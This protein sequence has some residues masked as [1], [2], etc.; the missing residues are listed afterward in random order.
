M[1]HGVLLANIG[2]PDGTGAGPTPLQVKA[3]LKEF[4]MDPFVIDIPFPIRWFLVNRM[5][6]PQRSKTSAEAYHKIWNFN[7]NEGSPLLSSMLKLVIK[8]Q[9]RLNAQQNRSGCEFIV[10]PAMRYG[11]PSFHTAI[12]ELKALGAEKITLCPLFPQYSTAAT[13]SSIRHFRKISAELLP[14]IAIAEVREFYDSPFFINA[15]AEVA[16]AAL[17]KISYDSILFSFHG[18]PERQVKKADPTGKHCLVRTNCCE[19]PAQT[20]CY[21][22]QCYRTARELAAKLNI[23]NDGYLVGFQSRLGRTPWIQPHTDALFRTIVEQGKT[24]LA[25]LCPSFV[26][27]CLETLEEIQIRGREMFLKHGGKEL[28]LIPSL[29]D[30]DVWAEALVGILML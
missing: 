16:R 5:I 25:V 27:D 23:P 15:F 24:R 10:K 26:A 8:V 6:L 7:R 30:S 22:A 12:S 11:N 13:E 20:R 19:T 21:R 14:S 17:S 28:T 1:K 29:N 4:L 3:Y 18:L 2:T 9:E